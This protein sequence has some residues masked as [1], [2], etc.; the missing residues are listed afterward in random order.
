MQENEFSLKNSLKNNGESKHS[1][2]SDNLSD[3][4]VKTDKLNK[5]YAGKNSDYLE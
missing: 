1:S 3:I 4:V 2:I 5:E